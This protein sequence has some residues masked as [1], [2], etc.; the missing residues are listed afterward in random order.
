MIPQKRKDVYEIITNRIIEKLEQGTI[1]W[2]RPWIGGTPKSLVSGKEYR[3]INVFM[4]GSTGYRD[5]LFLTYKQAKDKGGNVKKGEKGFPVIFWNWID[6]PDRDDETKTVSVPFVRYYT[7]FNV[8]QC[9]GIEYKQETFVRP[10]NPIASAE[11][12]VSDMPKR[13]LI[14][15]EEQR[16]FYRPSDDK[17]NM[18]E[19]DSF[20]SDE[21]YYST[22]F[23][24]LTHS[25]GHESRLNRMDSMKIAAFGSNSYSKEELCAEMGSAMLCG[26]CGIENETIEN[27]SAYIKG[28]LSKVRS[29]KKFLIQAAAQAQKAADFILGRKFE[30]E[31]K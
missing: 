4:L 8:E 31:G 18:P 25:T 13:P 5:A 12:I 11:K 28:W 21:E 24:E 26:T 10:L 23:H 1:P 27:Q 30:G 15:H 29:D 9:E 16:A 3:G 22:L 17:I 6:K 7:V 14:E 2:K 20:F 19:T